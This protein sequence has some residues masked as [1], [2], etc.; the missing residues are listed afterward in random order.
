MIG[1]LIEWSIRCLDRGPMSLDE[2]T[3]LARRFSLGYERV[4][5]DGRKWKDTERVQSVQRLSAQVC[6]HEHVCVS[7]RLCMFA[8]AS[9]RV[10]VQVCLC[11]HALYPSPELCLAPR[12]STTCASRILGCETI[13]WAM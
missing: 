13:K 2:Q 4:L 11:V 10:C 5:P 12:H 3:E 7:F 6:M 1:W 9:Y 8:C